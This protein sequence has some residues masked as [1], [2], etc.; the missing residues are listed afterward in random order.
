MFVSF[1]MY[2]SAEDKFMLFGIQ[3]LKSMNLNVYL[4]YDIIWLALNFFIFSSSNQS[5]WLYCMK[6]NIIE[7][8]NQI[9]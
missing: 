3:I 2:N 1:V 4:I 9:E 7:R 6:G 8:N 5:S